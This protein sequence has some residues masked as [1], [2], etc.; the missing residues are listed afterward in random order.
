MITIVQ[1]F[2]VSILGKNHVFTSKNEIVT[3]DTDIYSDIYYD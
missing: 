1:K 2:E 3:K